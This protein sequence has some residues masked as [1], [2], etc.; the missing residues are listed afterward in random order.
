MKSNLDVASVEDLM[1][2]YF[3]FVA[4]NTE[5]NCIFKL[6]VGYWPCVVVGLMQSRFQLFM[7]IIF[8]CIRMR[9]NNLWLC[10][11]L[12]YIRKN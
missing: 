1:I 11:I 7:D 2:L 6:L 10:L 8:C 3:A 9:N 12:V 4:N 5:L